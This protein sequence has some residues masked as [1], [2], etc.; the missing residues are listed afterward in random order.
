MSCNGEKSSS[1]AINE[2]NA[3]ALTF[4]KFVINS[5]PTAV[6]TVNADL[7]ITGFNPWAEKV[8]GYSAVE[9]LGNY[10][11]NILKGGMCNENCPLKTVLHGDAP[12]SLLTTTIHNKQGESISVRL[13]TAGLFDDKGKLVGGVES[14]QDISM[15][16]ALEREKGNLISMF[17]HD[18][19]SSLTIIG[20]F[21]L[22]LIRMKSGADETKRKRYL[23]IVKEEA[24]K[25]L[26]LVND[27]L[28]FS[29]LQLGKL[30]LN[31]GPTSLDKQL[32]ELFEVY[33]V[34]ASKHDVNLH[35][36]NT[37]ELPVISADE[38]RL[39]R[40]FT[41]LLDNALKFSKGGGNITI[42][43]QEGDQEITI[44]ITD[45]GIGIDPSD[46]PY[47]FDIFH[48]GE[49]AG[50]NQGHG[51]GLAGVKAIVEGHGGRVHV[52]SELGKGSV[53]T[54]VLPKSEKQNNGE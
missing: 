52:E 34:K 40:V 45:Q 10:C 42:S 54:V 29:R 43:T 20:G 26:F 49:N 14:F 15:I 2:A 17:A 36:D 51:L 41:N 8:T 44:K 23:H 24:E 53:F 25:L 13:N 4:Y 47:I 46:L 5:L 35:L 21:I 12:I 6:F 3:Q 33:Q 38:N 11:G 22:R 16:K 50:K 18:M 31:V 32:M 7:K 27:F 9:A 48:R 39:R 37:E 30:Q 1:A 28:E 19:K